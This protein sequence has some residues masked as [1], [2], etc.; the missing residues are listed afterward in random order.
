[1]YVFG[2]FLYIANEAVYFTSDRRSESD[3]PTVAGS[4]LRGKFND[5]ADHRPTKKTKRLSVSLKKSERDI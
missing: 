2:F 1:M 4:S 5:T 3:R